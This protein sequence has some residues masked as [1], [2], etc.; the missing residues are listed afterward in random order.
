MDL[1]QIRKLIII[2]ICSDNDLLD[3]LVLKGGNALGLVHGIGTRSSVDVDFSMAGDFDDLKDA[4]A[5][6]FA[7]LKDRFDSHGYIVFDEK[8]AQKP[9]K[10]PVDPE[11]GGYRVEFKLIG[12]EKYQELGGNLD[13]M[14]R[15]SLDVDEAGS[16][17]KFRIDISKYE[18]TGGF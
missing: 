12:R 13:A 4:E 8:F 7:A 3:V 18:Y 1:E 10:N 11:W 16:T 17:R 9:G 5:K 2:A 6:L 14:R 15:Q